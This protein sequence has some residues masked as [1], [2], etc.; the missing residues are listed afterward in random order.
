MDP[1]WAASFSATVFGSSLGGNVSVD[2]EAVSFLDVVNPELTL[3]VK[4][5]TSTFWDRACGVALVEGVCVVVF[6]PSFNLLIFERGAKIPYLGAHLKYW[7]LPTLPLF[8]PSGSSSSMPAHCPLANSVV[9]Q[10]LN[11]PTF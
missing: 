9:P 2:S 6:L 10:N 5:A 7:T 8:F 11:V 1:G 3:D 4:W